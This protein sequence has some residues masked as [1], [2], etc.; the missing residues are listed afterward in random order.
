[1]IYVKRKCVLLAFCG[2]NILPRV[3]PPGPVILGEKVMATC[4]IKLLKRTEFTQTVC[5]YR[6]AVENIKSC[7]KSGVGPQIK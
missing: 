5:H 4:H 1:M 2:L 6:T 3:F 7:T